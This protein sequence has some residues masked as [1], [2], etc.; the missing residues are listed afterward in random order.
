MEQIDIVMDGKTYRVDKLSTVKEFI[1]QF[2]PEEK[3]K[4]VLAFRNKKLCELG[5]VLD[6]ECEL[7]L[8]TAA[9]VIG[10][11]TYKRSL[12][13]LMLKSFADVIGRENRI[14]VMYSVG[15][16][17]YCKPIDS[18]FKITEDIIAKV[19][20]RMQELV[21]QDISFVKETVGTDEAIKRFRQQGMADKEK[22]F[23]FRRVSKVN[24]Y[25]LEGYEDYFYG[26]M[27]ASTGYLKYFDLLP[28]D[29]GVV[30]MAPAKNEPGV[31]PEYKPQEKLFHVLKISDEWSK[32]LDVDN[33]G[34]LNDVITNGD[35]RELML[36]QEALQE[37]QIASIAD[38]IKEGEKKIVLIAGPSSSGKTTF[39][40]RLS[41]QLRAHG[42]R[43]YP[44]ALDNYF[45]ERELTPKDENGNYDFEC[46]EAMDLALFN[47][48]MKRLLAGEEIDIPSFNFTIGKKEY[49]GKRLKLNDGDVLVAEGIHALNPLMTAQ[50]PDDS[51][52]KVY[53]SA[54]TQLNIDEHNRIPTTD[55]RLI[56]RIVR[57]ARTRGNNAR[58]TIGMW[59]SVRRG[60]E[61]YIFPFQEQA[62]VMFNSALIYELSVIKQFA[63]PLLFSVPRDCPEY[64]EA[65]RLLKFLDYFLGLDVTNVPTNSILREFVGG[66]CFDL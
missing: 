21:A 29:E 46:I 57:D 17:I 45:L 44:L 58:D 43:P 3:Y 51:K 31:I 41:V 10:N 63:E 6:K 34:D 2:M 5:T 1:W 48:D 32:M 28:Y 36:V 18:S 11:D 53:I 19:K 33:V 65:K 37:K 60:E 14:N 30:L 54:L 26:Y 13:F 66:G 12:K 16:G 35:I 56:R 47:S 22:L 23:S 9:S 61:K 20:S 62:D 24:I 27:V 4:Y 25:N 15:K 8:I 52:F 55:G 39:S 50:L 7:E 40:H 49:K 38:M 42:L 64:Y 59:N